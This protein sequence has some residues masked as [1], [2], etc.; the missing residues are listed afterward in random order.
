MEIDLASMA[1]Q[2]QLEWAGRIN[3][4]NHVEPSGRNA[5]GGSQR[6][7]EAY[8]LKRWWN[9]KCVLE[10]R[11]RHRVKGPLPGEIWV[12]ERLLGL[13]G[14]NVGESVGLG[15]RQLKVGAILVKEPD[16]QVGF[17]GWHQEY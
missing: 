3:F 7:S 6:V 15:T 5:T 14:V 4:P 17:E 9:G 13:L 12:S 8:P 11:F 16:M 2:H 10:K 1:E